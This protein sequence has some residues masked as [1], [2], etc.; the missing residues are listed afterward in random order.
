MNQIKQTQETYRRNDRFEDEIELID[1]LRVVWKWKWLIIGGT[2]LCI[3]AAAIYGF[4]RPVVKM[5][6]VSALIEIDPRAKLDPLDK[7]K[8]MMEYGIFNHQ[9]LN[10]LSK[11]QGQG[12]SN[13]ESLAFEVAIP[14][15]LNILDIGYKTPNADL[16][17]AVLD[18]LAKQIKENYAPAI[19]KRKAEW[20]RSLK[21]RN[22]S[23]KNIKHK[24]ELMKKQF[25]FNVLDTKIRI[26]EHAQNI[27][28]LKEKINLV[29]SRIGLME[30]TLQGAQSN[31]AKLAAKRSETALD[32]QDEAGHVDVFLQASAIQQII[33]YPIALRERIDSLIFEDKKLLSDILLSNNLIERMEKNIEILKLNHEWNITAKEEE[34]SRL[35]LE[36]ETSKRDRDKVTGLIMKQPPTASP[37]PIKYKTKRNT[38]LAGVVGFFFLIFFAFFIEYI[39]NAAKRAQKAV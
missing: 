7:I 14:K 10:D 15:G 2:L 19:E 23:I 26:K 32:S 18:S 20:E 17:K 24:I 16:G 30:K 39:K 3:L 31:S 21:K 22:E 33:D 27:E 6:K 1:Y 4:T 37:L 34:V 13:P 9:V 28:M 12:I 35:K 8:S 11:L 25:D 29:R 38:I 36:I 5:Y